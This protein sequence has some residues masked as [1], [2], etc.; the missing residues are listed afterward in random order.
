MI[1]FR[2]LFRE[3]GISTFAVTSVLMLIIISARLAKYLADAAAGKL[4]AMAVFLILL[5]RMPGFLELLLPLGLFL[6]VLLGYGRLYLDSEMVVMKAAGFSTRRLVTYTLG[7]ALFI[8]AL[9]ASLSLWLTPYGLSQANQVFLQQESR[10]ELDMLTPGRFLSQGQGQV[11]YA[12][13]FEDERLMQVFVAQQSKDGAPVLLF[14]EAAE[15]RLL[16]EQ[17]Q[18]FLVL[19]N[20]Y[21]YDGRPGDLAFTEIAYREYGILLP[22][23]DFSHEISDTDAIPTLQLMQQTDPKAKAALHWRLSL[24]VLALVVALIA[25][26]LSHAHPRQGRFARL[27]PAILGYLLYVGL[28]TTARS[29]IEKGGHPAI[30]WI[31]HLGFICLAFNLIAFSE[32][33]GRIGRYSVA[34]VLGRARRKVAA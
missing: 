32:F 24:P 4:E 27:I 16:T 7:P 20:G 13:R 15:R 9:V 22:E 33:W 23:P 29:A 21:R 3:V 18:R 28:L 30:I 26:P 1:L 17:N 19:H 2:Y 8:S 10:S 12:E 34:L 11:T 14:A 31:V 5:Y 25:V 6:G